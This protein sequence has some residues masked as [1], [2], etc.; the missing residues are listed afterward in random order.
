MG[1]GRTEGGSVIGDNLE[2]LEQTISDRFEHADAARL[3]IW[4]AEMTS[5][6]NGQVRLASEPKSTKRT[7]YKVNMCNYM[8]IGVQGYVGR[9][10][11]KHRTNKRCMNIAVYTIESSKWVFCR[12]F[13]QLSQFVDE[14]RQDGAVALKVPMEKGSSEQDEQPELACSAIDMV[15]Q[16]IPPIW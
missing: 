12:K 3:D 11:E 7:S 2:S 16:N 14:L 6:D 13:P 5:Y 10:F 4:E 15:I 9:G 8:S 1:W